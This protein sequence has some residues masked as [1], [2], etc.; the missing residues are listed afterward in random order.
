MI[1]N[2][3]DEKYEQHDHLYNSVYL[4]NSWESCAMQDEAN[5]LLLRHRRFN[6]RRMYI[7]PETTVRE[8]K[9]DRMETM[10]FI[11][12]MEESND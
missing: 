12:S 9:E 11:R 4:I 10:K 8:A 3:F 6:R 5:Y 7:T 1:K 2:Y